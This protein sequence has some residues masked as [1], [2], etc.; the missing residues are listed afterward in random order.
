VVDAT[1][2]PGYGF[3]GHCFEDCA[4][5]GRKCSKCFRINGKYTEF[6][7]EKAKENHMKIIDGC[8]LTNPTDEI[9]RLSPKP[10]PRRRVKRDILRQE[11]SRPSRRH[12]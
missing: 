7:P 10:P 1:F 2:C 11:R 8:H 9:I 12:A 4:N 5:R 6:K 3:Q